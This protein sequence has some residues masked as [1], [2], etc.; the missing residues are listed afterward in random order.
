MSNEKHVWFLWF[1]SNL[2]VWGV[3]VAEATKVHDTIID[4]IRSFTLLF[5][6]EWILCHWLRGRVV[7]KM[8]KLNVTM[9]RYL[10]GEAFRVLTAVEMGMK[11]HELV[12]KQVCKFVWIFVW[13]IP[14]TTC[15]KQIVGLTEHCVKCLFEY[16]A[17]GFNRRLEGRWGRQSSEGALQEPPSPVRQ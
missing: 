12:P 14:C 7:F 1:F 5:W 3:E 15:A 10:D 17:C 13:K 11:N 6:T 2:E 16:V 4:R 8:G 9:L